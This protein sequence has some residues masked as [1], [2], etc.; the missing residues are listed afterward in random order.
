[1]FHIRQGRLVSIGRVMCPLAARSV[2]MRL[3]WL[4][5]HSG[6]DLSPLAEALNHFSSQLSNLSP[7]SMHK[8]ASLWCAFAHLQW[9]RLVLFTSRGEAFLHGARMRSW[10]IIHRS[11]TVDQSHNL[12]LLHLSWPTELKRLWLIGHLLVT[13]AATE[14]CFHQR[15]IGSLFTQQ[16]D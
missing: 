2:T 1:M 4:V 8:T 13:T 11:V 6:V 16:D 15:S 7:T 10:Q 5:E 9:S 14:D 12:W 3:Q